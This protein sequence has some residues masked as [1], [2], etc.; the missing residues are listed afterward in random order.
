MLAYLYLPAAPCTF[1]EMINPALSGGQSPR[2]RSAP[3]LPV[4]SSPSLRHFRLD[5]RT[6]ARTMN[7]LQD[8][9]PGDW[10][11][12]PV[13]RRMWPGMT[14]GAQRL[15]ANT[16]D[17]ARAAQRHNKAERSFHADGRHHS[18]RSDVGPITGRRADGKDKSS[19]TV[20]HR[21][22]EHERRLPVTAEP[23]VAPRVPPQKRRHGLAGDAVRVRGQPLEEEDLRITSEDRAAGRC[24][25]AAREVGGR[26]AGQRA[27]HIP[28]CMQA[29]RAATAC[30]KSPE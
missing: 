13:P 29:A 19:L 15:G 10:K 1:P 22:D 14:P 24:T 7:A 21:E 30:A 3:S 28:A 25:G 6:G 2:D 4:R 9:R 17:H 27:D 20:L 8:L 11:P 5:F 12:A 26:V 16:G 23:Q 18:Q